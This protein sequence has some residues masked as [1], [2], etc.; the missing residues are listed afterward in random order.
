MGRMESAGGDRVSIHVH[1]VEREMAGIGLRRFADDE[2]PAIP[3]DLIVH[4]A[5]IEVARHSDP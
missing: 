4:K 1:R 2:R 5:V 3:L